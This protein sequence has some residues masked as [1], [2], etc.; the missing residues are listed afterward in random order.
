LSFNTW[1][2]IAPLSFIPGLND[3]TF[4]D[5]IDSFV[6]KILLPV[7]GILLALFVGWRLPDKLVLDELSIRGGV[8]F[9]IWK[10]FLRY[11]APAAIIA[12]FLSGLVGP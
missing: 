9:K 6:S 8:A 7:S 2:D 10:V 12:L 11:V 4:F 3:K 5:L 1:A